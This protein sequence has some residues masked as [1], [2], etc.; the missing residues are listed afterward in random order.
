M[1]Q[2]RPQFDES[3]FQQ[4]RECGDD[5]LITYDSYNYNLI[6]SRHGEDKEV[7]FVATKLYLYLFKR[8]GVKL[9]Y[10]WAL[11]DASVMQHKGRGGD[12][13]TLVA[14]TAAAD[15]PDGVMADAI[16]AHL[17][18]GDGTKR[19]DQRLAYVGEEQDYFYDSK[20]IRR[21][22]VGVDSAESRDKRRDVALGTICVEAPSTKV[23]GDVFDCIEYQII[24]SRNTLWQLS[25]AELGKYRRTDRRALLLGGAG[26]AAARRRRQKFRVRAEE[27]DI[28]DDENVDGEEDE[29]ADDEEAAVREEMERM[30]DRDEAMLDDSDSTDA[31]EDGS[32]A[33]GGG[34]G[35]GRFAVAGS[36]GNN[37][38]VTGSRRGRGGAD[39]NGV[40][41]FSAIG[42]LL[43]SDVID[44]AV[45]KEAFASQVKGSLTRQLRLFVEENAVRVEDLC[46]I[47][48]PS[49]LNASQQCHLV[50]SEDARAVQD[51]LAAAVKKVV[52]S[53]EDIRSVVVGLV[54]AHDTKT[55]MEI[56]VSLLNKIYLAARLL[57][58]AERMLAEGDYLGAVTTKQELV[59]LASTSL[60]SYVVGEYVLT[61]RAPAIRNA[62]LN[63]GL[64][65]A[66]QWLL[67][68]RKGCGAVGEALI[69]KR[70]IAAATSSTNT[71][72]AAVFSQIMSAE[73]SIGGGGGG[74]FGASAIGTAVAAP[75]SGGYR[76]KILF[77]L[78]S[79]PERWGVVDEYVPSSV[80]TFA[81]F[82][83]GGSGG[84]SS[85]LGPAP[86]FLGPSSVVTAKK[87]VVGGGGSSKRIPPVL[88]IN[89]SSNNGGGG[90]GD[91]GGGGGGRVDDGPLAAATPMD[92]ATRI[93]KTLGVVEE[94]YLGT[95][96][97]VVGDGASIQEL[98]NVA[99]QGEGFLAYYASNRIKQLRI[100]LAPSAI[101]SAD[102][103]DSPLL[104]SLV[105]L[106]TPPSVAAALAAASS[107]NNNNNSHHTGGGVSS[108]ASTQGISPT[109]TNNSVGDFAALTSA[110]TG[111]PINNSSTA[112]FAPATAAAAASPPP[113]PSAAA[114]KAVETAVLTILGPLVK[115]LCLAL[116][117]MIVEDVVFFNTSPKLM[118]P[119]DI[120][121]IWEAF[122]ADIANAI[123]GC[124]NKIQIAGGG[125]LSPEVV[126]ATMLALVALVNTF[127]DIA[128]A[129]V[130]CTELNT[131]AIKR[132]L[133]QTVSNM[134]GLYLVAHQ[135]ALAV[136]LESDFLDPI[137][138]SSNEE[139]KFLITDYS[140]NLVGRAQHNGAPLAIPVP[141]V[142]RSGQLYMPFSSSVTATV[143]QTLLFLDR[144]LTLLGGNV[145]PF[146]A[147][148]TVPDV[149]I[150]LVTG[151]P[152]P[153][154]GSPSS[155]DAFLG[156]N[157]IDAILIENLK[158]LF[159]FVSGS[160]GVKLSMLDERNATAQVAMMITNAY[161]LGVVVTIVEQ[162]F[163]LWW[164]GAA[165]GGGAG[166]GG[167][168]G[169]GNLASASDLAVVAANPYLL[170]CHGEAVLLRES[171]SL[172]DGLVTKA[173]DKLLNGLKGA[174]EDLLRP[175]RSLP[176]WRRRLAP[177]ILQKIERAAD[178]A[179]RR[180]GEVNP[181]DNA[182][183]AAAAD[184]IRSRIPQ[185]QQ[186]L[187]PSTLQGIVGFLVMHTGEL[188]YEWLYEAV[189]SYD[190]NEMAMVRE[191]VN[192]MVSELTPQVDDW[193]L[194]VQTHVPPPAAGGGGSG[195]AKRGGGG[196]GS[197]AA[198]AAYRLPMPIAAIGAELHR[199]VDAREA[200]W[201]TT[202]ENE[203]RIKA[204][205]EALTRLIVDN[206]KGV[207][208][209]ATKV[210]WLFG[211]KAVDI[212]VATGKLA[213]KATT[214]GGAIGPGAAEERARRREER[215][216]KRAMGGGG[217]VVGMDASS[218]NLGSDHNDSSH[219]FRPS[220]EG[221][222][223]G[224]GEA[225][226]DL[227]AFFHEQPTLQ[228][229]EFDEMED[230]DDLLGRQKTDSANSRTRSGG[231]GA[232]SVAHSRAQSLSYSS[233]P[234]QPPSAV[235]PRAMS[236]RAQ[237]PAPTTAAA[238]ASASAFLPAPPTATAPPSSSAADSGAKRMT[239]AK[240]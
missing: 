34:A 29:E 131:T 199:W 220:E 37:A 56:T 202:A 195:G 69:T 96:R 134:H 233:P 115:L 105:V 168:G 67:T 116:G 26:G 20:G 217:G 82:F 12:P 207:T 100:D 227:E 25:R 108:A 170:K 205:A 180:A 175:I 163:C 106:A 63:A 161:A 166:G 235:A 110:A 216:R 117:T 191:C 91:S 150:L 178:G 194:F 5:Y 159:K 66:N 226:E 114:A 188:L 18:G 154:S 74:S 80:A 62:A 225:I 99:G 54:E 130:R 119:F 167:S 176:Y 153:Y 75:P 223:E 179:G 31:E 40:E 146:R 35:Y 193:L 85:L 11:R 137:L 47:H 86:A 160:M 88:N 57:Q 212:G 240:R 36:S 64:A 61:H 23:A 19:D 17:T 148:C 136:A 181:E 28:E 51:E 70:L 222:G 133:E 22:R 73:G 132:A 103:A 200:Y 76:R 213:V 210:G 139:F 177:S 120:T 174:L 228:P 16:S 138:I 145:P 206:A 203:M 27:D 232:P 71:N 112:V 113:S 24:E 83:G 169:G 124:A 90:G 98:F 60:S 190:G 52:S 46:K 165:L 2:Y 135:M 237:S 41:R 204:E 201:R 231:G 140:L 39:G 94:R 45:L 118:S 182:G 4:L 127:T 43:D 49:F 78:K 93:R 157:N 192:V 79:A 68:I 149:N 53:V 238:S 33:G 239:R 123:V 111:N 89:S 32:P 208:K 221:G 209:A 122:S 30:R 125:G 48:Y 101:A 215:R 77:S 109:I 107:S 6:I 3:V 8:K 92:D 219:Y 87:I 183:F 171:Q 187:P 186:L 236:R 129:N 185:L 55:N 59:M 104:Q 42:T 10:R 81:G 38:G 128:V 147:E 152:E 9:Y 218:L 97:S 58:Q 15:D 144:C 44:Y 184:L 156:V 84:L 151:F 1:A 211:R 7:F 155:E 13:G 224:G 21:R 158:V 197:S 162:R 189:Q 141:Q 50:R 102:L 126:D 121:N 196:L 172:F 234:S 198:P 164:D 143:Q 95:I 142:Y 72:A 65:R 229:P 230:L 214:L 173:S 14:V